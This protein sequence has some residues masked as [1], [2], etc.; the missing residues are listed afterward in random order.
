MACLPPKVDAAWHLHELTE[1]M[2][3]DAFVLFSSAAGVL[4]SPGQGNYAAANAF[5]DGLAFYRRARGLAGLSIAWGLWAQ[6]SGLTGG[7]GEG[8]CVEDRPPGHFA[9]FERGRAWSCS[10]TRG[11]WVPRRLS[12]CA[13][14]SRRCVRSRGWVVA[15][16]VAWVGTCSCAAGWCGW[17]FG[18]AVGWCAGG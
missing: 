10:T 5:L 18:A 7:L 11:V 15:R 3:L 2:G 6:V 16:D 9:A 1:G 8:G 12:L 4:G 17:V 14:M 13:W